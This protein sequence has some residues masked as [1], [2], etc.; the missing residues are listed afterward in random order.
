L[1]DNQLIES[2]SRRSS[3]GLRNYEF[4]PHY[5]VR[6]TSTDD[7]ADSLINPRYLYRALTAYLPITLPLS[8]LCSLLFAGLVLLFFT[9]V[10]KASAI[11]KIASYT[12]YIAYVTPEQP[13]KSLEFTQTQV[14]LL[15]NPLAIERI[16]DD[17]D[18]VNL[19]EIRSKSNPVS[20]LASNIV[21]KQT[22]TSEL[23]TVSLET[24]NPESSA[25]ILN[26]VLDGYFEIRAQD[27]EDQTKRVIELLSKEKDA[28]AEE[29]QR[30]REKIRQLGQDMNGMDPFTGLPKTTGEGSSSTPDKLRDQL[31]K[32][33]VDRRMLEMEITVIREAINKKEL[34]VAEVD[35]ELAVGDS[36]A[37]SDLRTIIAELTS[38]LHRIE[39]TAAGGKQDPSYLRVQQEI[40]AYQRQLAQA[41]SEARPRVVNDMESIAKLDRRDTLHELESRLETQEVL[42]ALLRERFDESLGTASQSGDKR[43]E[44]EFARSELEREERVFE[45]IAERQMALSTESRAPGRVALMQPATPPSSPTASFPIRDLALATIFGGL[46]PFGFALVWELKTK[47]ISTPEQLVAD[48]RLTLVREVAKLPTPM[49]PFGKCSARATKIFE[50]SIDSLRVGITL[51]DTDSPLQVIAVTSA[52]QSEGKSSVASQLAVSISRATKSKVLL[53]DGDLRSPDMHNIFQI[54]NREGLSDVL[55][56]N[57]GIEDCIVHGWSDHL[58]LLP[59]GRAN[60]NPHQLITV[61][62]LS[63][64]LSELRKEYQY[65][66]L[67]TPPILSASEALVLARSADGAILCTRCNSSR[68]SQV[69]YAYDRLY[70]AGITPLGAVLNGVPTHRYARAYG[71]YPEF[72]RES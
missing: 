67:D 14:E 37:V 30:L 39:R 65:I 40:S 12:P 29:I 4:T 63:L 23:Y 38:K 13:L 46:L 52:V 11:M 17:E 3:S 64:V 47:P 27:N 7:D 36:K 72:R 24:P 8:I 60:V 51:A 70:R 33:E 5:V 1:S 50:E 9:P 16:L 58:D 32:A 42:E 54:P 68:E 10:Y 45:M 2:D 49:I 56:G 62:S 20:W 44:L 59:A 22:G 66:V 55:A 41:V 48:G 19:P 53:I 34:R 28:R 69:R 61:D 25:K 15:R 18:V 21:I 26:A 43:L 57:R 71:N 6:R 31:T 35:V